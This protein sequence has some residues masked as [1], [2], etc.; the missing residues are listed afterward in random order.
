M[1]RIALLRENGGESFGKYVIPGDTITWKDGPFTLEARIEQDSETRPD[2]FD[3]MDPKDVAAWNR[4]E[5]FYCGITVSVVDDG[6]D[7][8][9]LDAYADREHIIQKRYRG[10]SES[11]WGIEANYPGTDNSYLTQ[12]AHELGEQVVQCAQGVLASHQG[13]Q[14]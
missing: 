4:D 1:K 3:G 5:W 14:G 2:D 10:C 11:L 9:A 8:S 13:G 7:Y 6:A 12:T